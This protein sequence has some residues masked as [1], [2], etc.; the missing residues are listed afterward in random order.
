M[1]A[2]EN[3]AIPATIPEVVPVRRGLPGWQLALGWIATALIVALNLKLL[4]G[5][6]LEG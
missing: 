6:V 4:S 3:V 1:S 5:L 2:S